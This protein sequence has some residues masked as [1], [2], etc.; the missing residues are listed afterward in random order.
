MSTRIYVLVHIH[1]S[2]CELTFIVV[3]TSKS[4]RLKLELTHVFILLYTNVYIFMIYDVAL[5][6]FSSHAH[7]DADDIRR[8]AG[9]KCAIFCLYILPRRR[10][11]LTPL[12]S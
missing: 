7:R 10:Y 2:Q 4:P 12:D 9:L 1:T 11:S 8:L 5:G 3:A 6:R